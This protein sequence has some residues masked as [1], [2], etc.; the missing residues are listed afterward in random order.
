MPKETRNPKILLNGCC[1][2]DTDLLLVRDLASGIWLL[3]PMLE[4]LTTTLSDPMRFGRKPVAVEWIARSVTTE[5]GESDV[6]VQLMASNGKRHRLLFEN[7]VYAIFQPDQAE[8][9][10]AR[11]RRCVERGESDGATIVLV[12]PT[13][14]GGGENCGFDTRINY[15]WLLE[16][17]RVRVAEDASARYGVALLEAALDKSSSGYVKQPVETKTLFWMAYHSVAM[18]LVPQLRM[19]E[20]VASGAK[21][22]WISFRPNGL[23]KRCRLL[24]KMPKGVVHLQFGP[25]T[26]AREELA[27]AQRKGSSPATGIRLVETGKSCSWEI[28]VPVVDPDTDFEKE[29]DRAIAGMRAAARLWAVWLAASAWTTESSE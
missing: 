20:P 6:E 23:P 19:P 18:D 17:Y 29:R 4:L 9:Y 11:A 26:F 8:R 21:N 14:Y 1:E 25:G 10:A 15:E 28:E 2:R 3:E 12:A 24:H 7:K 5:D 13:E 22:N 16:R 27:S